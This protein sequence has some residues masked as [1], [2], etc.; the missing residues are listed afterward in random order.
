MLRSS[1][2]AEEVFDD[3]RAP[4]TVGT[5]LRG[6]NWAAARMLDR[7]LRVAL[8]RAWQAGLGPDLHSDLTLRNWALRRRRHK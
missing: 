1:A 5:W 3:T 2:A 7:V 8:R 4:S 6:F